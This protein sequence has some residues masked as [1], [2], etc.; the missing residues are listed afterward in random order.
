MNV[1]KYIFFSP[2]SGNK[3]DQ[4]KTKKWKKKKKTILLFVMCYLIKKT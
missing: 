2:K 1:D 3:W 4:E